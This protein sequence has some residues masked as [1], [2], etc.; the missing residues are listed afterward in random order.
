MTR[1]SRLTLKQRT[2][3]QDVVRDA[4]R[5]LVSL[6]IYLIYIKLFNKRQ[7]GSEE[8]KSVC[9]IADDVSRHAASMTG[10][11]AAAAAGSHLFG[12]E[13]LCRD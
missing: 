8:W 9:V 2:Y 4:A 1:E 13:S 10:Q 12:G 5:E 11:S 6:L 3:T 7:H